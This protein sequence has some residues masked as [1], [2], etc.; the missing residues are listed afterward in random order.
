M[1]RSFRHRKQAK[2]RIS[3]QSPAW[4]P[5]ALRIAI[6]AVSFALT[7]GII[8]ADLE[9]HMTL[10]G[11]EV[12]DPA[13]RTFFSPFAFV[14]IDEDATAAQRAERVSASPE[15]Y[16]LDAGVEKLAASHADQ[17]FEAFHSVRAAAVEGQAPAAVDPRTLPV[18]LSAVTLKYLAEET[19][20][21]DTRK[22][23]EILF[24]HAYSRGLLDPE[25]KRSLF[26]SGRREIFLQTP[27]NPKG[28]FRQAIEIPS[29]EEVRFKL[30]EAMPE[31]LSRKKN[32]KAALQ[33]L[34]ER[35]VAP[36]VTANEAETRLRR[37]AAEE[38]VKPVEEEVKKDELIVQRGMLITGQEKRK[39]DLI[40]RKRAQK[41]TLKKLSGT[42]LLVAVSYSLFFIYLAFFERRMFRSMKYIVLFQTVFVLNLLVCKVINFWPGS[43]PYLMPGALASLCLALL[44]HPRFGVPASIVMTVLIAP[45]ANFAPDVLFGILLSGIAG[46]FAARQVRKRLEFLRIGFA[47]GLVHF[48]IVFA[49]RLFQEFGAA[50]SLQVAS[51]GFIKG[52]LVTVP[53][54]FILVT[55]LEYVFN[56]ATD[57]TL[58]ELSD[59]NHPLLRRM[60]IE[61][62]GTYH[63]S[64]VVSRLAES[65]CEQIGANALLARVGAY[66]HD[67]GKIARSEF[68][69]ENRAGKPSRHEKLTPAVSSNIIINHVREGIEL[70]R[71]HKLKESV[72]RFIPEHQG[73]GVVY[74]F[75]RRALDQAQP[76]EEINPDDF[77]YPGPKPQ[78]RETAVTLLADSV[79][80]ASRSLRDPTAESIRTQVQKIINDKFIDGQLDEC[81]L[82]LRDLHRIQ[83]TFVQNLMAIFHTRVPYPDK[84][85]TADNPDLFADSQ[86]RSLRRS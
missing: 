61:A 42:C 27:E 28:A 24:N 19:Q 47:V 31:S 17:I 13:P 22:N 72:L 9:P 38:S 69:T 58:L 5:G 68:F 78:S 12:G 86:T 34:F 76:G 53:S 77:R 2:V 29:L 54:L 67:I 56:L 66:F 3:R 45:L 4:L 25:K 55:L 46:T 20:L 62:P 30:D 18:E 21:E 70:G 63:H 64:L 32:Q 36:N 7:A 26:A 11:F 37:T 85:V 80:A 33:E 79:E 41:E 50:E 71:K 8:A 73:T 39:L 43:S 60:I 16:T 6:L 35:L 23:L 15:V 51:L 84:P 10:H 52:F 49:V 1:I 74:Y 65:A 81:D 57:I 75:Y 40:Q 14:Y 83:D 82:T 59:L 44:V 48:A